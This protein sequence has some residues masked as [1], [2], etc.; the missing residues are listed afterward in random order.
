VQPLR[1]DLQKAA[2][3]L[4]GNPQQQVQAEQLIEQLENAGRPQT[5]RHR[6]KQ[7]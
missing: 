2:K 6:Y 4:A 7:F 5:N 3:M 1:A